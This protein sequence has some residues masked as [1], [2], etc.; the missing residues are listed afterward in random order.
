MRNPIKNISLL[1]NHLKRP[2][3]IKLLALLLLSIL[4]AMLEIVFIAAVTII[5]IGE[6]G[7]IPKS[8]S[9]IISSSSFLDQLFVL[10][11]ITILVIFIK[12]ANI[13][14]TKKLCV[15]ASEDLVYE[16]TEKM[17]DCSSKHF[18]SMDRNDTITN[19]T[20]RLTTVTY[21]FVFPMLNA[22]TASIS[23]IL[24]VA[25]ATNAD[26]TALFGIIIVVGYFFLVTLVTERYR[27]SIGSRISKLLSSM[28]EK[29]TEVF[30]FYRN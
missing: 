23:I 16:F 10:L 27:N 30:E 22:I 24:I 29:I 28:N 13:F 17:F 18:F 4:Q 19:F 12:C 20:S 9:Y 25:Y 8:L 1:F 6:V 14:F 7:N 3:K 2:T 5:I 15:T 26:L 11:S 21:G